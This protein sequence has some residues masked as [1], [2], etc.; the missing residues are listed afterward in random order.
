MSTV[1]AAPLRFGVRGPRS[2]ARRVVPVWPTLAASANALAVYLVRPNVADLQ[3]ALA[4]E[5]AAAHGVGLTY[6]FQWFG[7]GATPGNYS[8][9]TPYLSSLIGALLLGVLATLV[10]TPLTAAALVGTRYAG[11]G[12]WIA[13]IAFGLNIWS[14]RIPFAVG[15]AVGVAALIGVRR[16][17]WALAVVGSIVA[18]LCSPVCGVFV[19]LALVGAIVVEPAYRRIAF[20]AGALCLVTLSLVAV[21]FGS[22]GPQPYSDRQSLITAGT[23]AIMLAARPPKSVRLVLI[24]T[25]IAAVA[26]TLFPNGLGSNFLRFPLVCLPGV[27]VAS[28]RS[29]RVVAVLCV[30]PALA[31]LAQLTV[32]D[33]KLARTPAAS[34]SYYSPLIGELHT[35]P[36]LANYR[37]EVVQDVQLHTAAYALINHVALAG[38]WETQQQNALNG[39]LRSPTLLDPASYK[40]WLDNTAVGYIAFDRRAATTAPEYQLVASRHLR[41][42]HPVW[43]DPSWILYRVEAPTP[44]VAAPERLVA[45][46]QSGLTIDVPCACSFSVRVRYSKFLGAATAPGQGATANATVTND[47]AGWTVLTTPTRGRYVLHGRFTR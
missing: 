40:L 27:V 32:S 25:M 46:T 23:A 2:M 47:G 41:Y 30:V 12:T 20:S 22:P 33:L 3:A 26:L 15:C 11:S 34:A 7:G 21:Y 9:L 5:S 39:L 4:R 13:T 10:I 45:A 28:A 44:I 16:H 6:W 1:F 14:G 43:H 31:F 38:G 29:R 37:L 17:I 35:L 24:G 42:L 36:Q 19:A 18:A 8:I